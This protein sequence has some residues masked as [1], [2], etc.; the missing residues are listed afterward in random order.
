MSECP[1]DKSEGVSGAESGFNH[2][3]AGDDRRVDR[4]G[5]KQQSNFI[6]AGSRRHTN[7][8]NSVN[9][10]GSSEFRSAQFSRGGGSNGRWT[11]YKRPVSLHP[12]SDLHGRVSVW[13]GR[14]G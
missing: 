11:C 10:L 8:G 3:L 1:T 2:W 9:G 6:A 13:L 5:R 4:A 12:A 7:R 14:S